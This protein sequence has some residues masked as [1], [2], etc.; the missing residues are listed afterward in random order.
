[1]LKTSTKN[2]AQEVVSILI[3]HSRERNYGLLPD[4]ELNFLNKFKSN[5]KANR[6]S[7]R[8]NDRSAEIEDCAE[9]EDGRAEEDSDVKQVLA[10]SCSANIN[11]FANISDFNNKLS[12]Q[13]PQLPPT[14]NYN[15]YFNNSK[16][17]NSS[18]SRKT[19]TNGSSL[20]STQNDSRSKISNAKRSE[21]SNQ[22]RNQEIGMRRGS[23]RTT[24]NDRRGARPEQKSTRQDKA[25]LNE[26]KSPKQ[27]D[28]E[29]LSK[30][31][32]KM[33]LT[34]N[35][36]ASE[37]NFYRREGTDNMRQVSFPK[38]KNNT[39]YKTQNLS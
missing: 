14:V 26:S 8:T 15:N 25:K 35:N 6:T 12:N 9:D 17:R 13:P 21:S 19:T 38:I 31:V 10:S 23:L 39:Q 27:T 20:G 24:E 33:S 1:M 28:V 16:Y 30:D 37:V 18:K 32:Y 7:G 22:P 29:S 11:K 36:F 34:S 5:A 3:N 4:L 2:V